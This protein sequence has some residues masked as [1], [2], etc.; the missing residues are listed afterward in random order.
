MW[1]SRPL[2]TDRQRQPDRHIEIQ[3]QT[4]AERRTD[5][6]TEREGG[7]QTDSQ[8]DRRTVRQTE[9]QLNEERQ[10]PVLCVG[11]AGMHYRA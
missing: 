5:R 4:E 3:T 10:G 7:G 1:N 9:A 8:T 2:T 11:V 6:D